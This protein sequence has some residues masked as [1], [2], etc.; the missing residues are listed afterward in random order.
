MHEFLKSEKEAHILWLTLN[1]PERRNALSTPICEALIALPQLIEDD[2]D[3]RCVVIT[4]EGEAFCAGADLKERKELDEDARRKYV[5]LVDQALLDVENSSA[6]H[7]AING[8]A[9][10]GT[11]LATR[12]D[13]RLSGRRRGFWSGRDRHRDHSE[14]QHCVPIARPT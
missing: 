13:I 14:R 6:R 3:I 10:G 12:C 8:Q 2:I 4:G 7:A 9:L 5:E 11:E 1:R